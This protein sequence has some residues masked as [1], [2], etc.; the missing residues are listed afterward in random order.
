MH[1]LS[2][3]EGSL[4]IEGQYIWDSTVV[5]HRNTLYRYALSADRGLETN[6]RH[7]FARLRLATSNDGGSTWIDEGSPF[8]NRP[9]GIWP[10]GTWPDHVIW[11]STVSVRQTSSG[12]E[13]ILMITGRSKMDGFVQKIGMATS[14][15]GRN[16][17][18]PV[19]ILD[20]L[21]HPAKE[22]GYDTQDVD[23]TKDV[24]MAWRDPF[25]FHDHTDKKWHMFFAAKPINST[26][27]MPRGT[28]G[29]AVALDD[30]LS[31]W[32][33]RE[34][35]QLPLYYQQLEVPSV[36]YREGEYFLFVSTQNSPLKE[37]N[38]EKEAAFRGYR[39]PSIL[40]PWK[41]V[42]ESTD[43]IFGHEVYGT[44]VFRKG[45]EAFAVA[46]FSEDT[47]WPVVGTPIVPITWQNQAPSI[48]FRVQ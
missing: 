15:D 24:I 29:H 37:T 2:P 31:N 7:D 25:L 40:G 39:A 18:D 46:F 26:K 23:P 13:F 14:K 3:P 5:E 47:P 33:L 21:T 42:Y 38:R 9:E 30:T 10:T 19:V 36:I 34:P 48:T 17:S 6:K 27:S 44:T 11:T 41:P 28:V 43:F 4:A 35:L 8:E 1:S 32:E 22:R 45:D 16:F 12:D 20:P